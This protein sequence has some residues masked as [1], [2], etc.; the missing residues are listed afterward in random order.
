MPTIKQ[1]FQKIRINRYIGSND[2]LMDL[3][4]HDRYLQVM[5]DI[6]Y[7][8]LDFDENYA[9]SLDFR[10][11]TE[12]DR[13]KVAEF[14][15]EMN[16]LYPN[17]FDVKLCVEEM[18]KEFDYVLTHPVEI[19]EVKGMKEK[20]ESLSEIFDNVVEENEVEVNEEK[21]GIQVFDIPEDN[22]PVESVSE[23]NMKVLEEEDKYF[24]T[25]IYDDDDEDLPEYVVDENKVA[26][27]NSIDELIYGT[28]YFTDVHDLLN[29]TNDVIGFSASTEYNN[30]WRKRSSWVADKN[31]SD[32]EPTVQK[33]PTEKEDYNYRPDDARIKEA[34]TAGFGNLV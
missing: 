12:N 18:T 34:K 6:A 2:N 26:E 25:G 7:G 15:N 11:I 27:R 24:G 14:V 9:F 28:N 8:K 29:K 32:R 33:Q 22:G 31:V 17:T 23:Y 20:D 30:G 5:K 1:E 21:S 16:E 19:E 13:E 4:V 3:P 10:K